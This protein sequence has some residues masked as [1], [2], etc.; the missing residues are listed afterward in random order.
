LNCPSE[1]I[2]QYQETAASGPVSNGPDWQ[3]RQPGL[4]HPAPQETAMLVEQA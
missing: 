1:K 3:I 4:F 2:R